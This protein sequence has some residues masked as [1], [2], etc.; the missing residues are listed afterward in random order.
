MTYD[1]TF[2]HVMAALM[3]MCLTAAGAVHKVLTAVCCCT[4]IYN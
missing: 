2:S 1:T 4:T 3:N